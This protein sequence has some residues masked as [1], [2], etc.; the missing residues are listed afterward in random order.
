[1]SVPN[2]G[3]LSASGKGVSAA[4][5]GP[6][7]RLL[8]RAVGKKKRKLNSI[9]KVKLNVAITYTPTGGSPN[10]QSVKVKLIKR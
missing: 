1:V 8:I 6:P 7:N 10:T 5:L 9:G 3:E 2:E 4:L